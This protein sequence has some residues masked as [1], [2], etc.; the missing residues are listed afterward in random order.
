M[1][2]GADV[3]K[4]VKEESVRGLTTSRSLSGVVKTAATEATETTEASIAMAVN[5][6]EV[7]GDPSST[8]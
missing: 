5:C 7:I 2:D 8:T 3:E 1:G 6:R 4:G